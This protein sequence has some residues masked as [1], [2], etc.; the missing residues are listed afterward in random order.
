ML[1]FFSALPMFPTVLLEPNEASAEPCRERA[2]AYSQYYSN[3]KNGKNFRIY[4][5][6]L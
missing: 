4:I 3:Q 5:E 2:I 1:P 6:Q